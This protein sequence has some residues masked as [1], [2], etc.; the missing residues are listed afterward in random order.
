MNE[1]EIK[2]NNSNTETVNIDDIIRNSDIKIN[3]LNELTI[4]KDEQSSSFNLME[5][6]KSNLLQL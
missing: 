5:N 6:S 1:N 2:I 4:I 3:E